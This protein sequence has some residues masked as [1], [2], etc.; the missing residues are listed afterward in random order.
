[1]LCKI[2]IYSHRSKF[3]YKLPNPQS[4]IPNPK[5]LIYRRIQCVSTASPIPI[6]KSQSQIPNPQ[7]Q[8]PNPKSP[9]PNPK[10]QNFLQKTFGG[11]KKTF[12]LSRVIQNRAIMPAVYTVSPCFNTCRNITAATVYAFYPPPL[13]MFNHRAASDCPTPLSGTI[14]TFAD[15][16]IMHFSRTKTIADGRTIFCARAKALSGERITL[17]PCTKAPSD[18]RTALPPCTNALSDGWEWATGRQ[19]RN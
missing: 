16:R 6:P 14:S 13:T 15:G 18:E 5:P 17:A 9:I 3:N 8:I 7:S 19:N 12:Y 10:S 1:M 4:P 11:V 2:F